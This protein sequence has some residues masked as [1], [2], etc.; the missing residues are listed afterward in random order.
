[1]PDHIKSTPVALIHPHDSL[2]NHQ[3]LA[4]NELHLDSNVAVA[5]P[6]PSGKTLVLHLFTVEMVTDNPDAA[7]L[8]LRPA[9]A[10]ANGQFLR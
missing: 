9:K 7:A 10:L 6:T 8:V 4:F 3:A 5:T 1:M 2:W